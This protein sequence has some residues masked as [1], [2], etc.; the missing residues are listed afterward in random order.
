M[1]TWCRL[2]VCGAVASAT[3][4]AISAKNNTGTGWTSI[5]LLAPE[6][7]KF[8]VEPLSSWTWEQAL[9]FPFLFVVPAEVLGLISSAIIYV[10]GDVKTDLP[11]GKTTNNPLGTRDLCYIWFNR[12]IV[13]PFL[14]W[15][16]VRTVWNSKA[17]VYDPDQLTW[18]NGALAFVICFA[19]SDLS[20]Y[21]SHRIVHKYKWLYRFVHKHHHGEP[22]PILGWSDTCN[23]TPMDFFYTG[24]TTSPMSSLWL[25]PSNSIHIYA[26]MACL[27]TNAFV[28]SLGHCRLDLNW[29]VFNTRFHAGHHAYTNCNY[30]QNVELWDRLFGTY[31]HLEVD[32]RRGL[33]PPKCD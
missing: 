31:R 7:H 19:L 28:G 8:M 5:E 6:S 32:D 12:L 17:V 18:M 29:G 16:I 27:W 14:S 15:M 23:A 4:A 10:L 2:F 21:T 25:F 30:A 20:Y 3:A 24:F 33:S 9:L 22:E 11:H 13:L 1:A 26:I